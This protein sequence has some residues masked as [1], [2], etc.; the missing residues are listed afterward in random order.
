MRPAHIEKESSMDTITFAYP[1]LFE[2]A[3]EGG[4]VITSRDLPEVV[5]Q[6]EDGEDRVNIAEGALQAAIEGRL[7]LDK[8]IPAPSGARRHEVLVT[9][10][11]E[12]A[13]KA[14]LHRMVAEENISK[15]DLARKI[16]LDEKEVRRLLDPQHSSKVP[17]IADA[18]AAYG[19]RL[20]ISIVKLSDQPVPDVRMEK[21]Y[22]EASHRLEVHVIPHHSGWAVKGEGNLR[23]SSIHGT[24]AEAIHAARKARSWDVVVHGRD[25]KI[26]EKTQRRDPMPP[27]EKAARLSGGSKKGRA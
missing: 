12:T 5:S 24:K 13:T 21:L 27:R 20:Q 16:D 2:R 14:A 4:W 1:I 23:A 8:V 25:G 19:R 7:L 3:E 10:P 9:V 17:R 15:S 11:V 22:G 18:L 6:A 26:Q